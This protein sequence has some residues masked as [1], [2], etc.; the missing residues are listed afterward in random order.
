M[1]KRKGPRRVLILTDDEERL[2]QLTAHLV[3]LGYEVVATASKLD[4][5]C[6]LETQ[7]FTA[8]IADNC[9]LEMSDGL[10]L[11]GRIAK[12]LADPVTIMSGGMNMAIRVLRHGVPDTRTKP[13]GTAQRP[14]ILERPYPLGAGGKDDPWT[15]AIELIQKVSE[16]RTA[17]ADLISDLH[18]V[19]A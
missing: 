10:N 9:L 16:E 12:A 4:A 15:S 13:L 3:A 17:P 6:L 1:T 18:S 2:H 7:P 14:F 5:L 11:R 19:P 8:A